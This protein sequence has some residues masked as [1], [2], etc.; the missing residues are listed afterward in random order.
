VLESLKDGGKQF[1]VFY[2]IEG[3]M[4]VLFKRND[5]KFGLY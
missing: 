1:E 2:D 3:K 5:G 4:R